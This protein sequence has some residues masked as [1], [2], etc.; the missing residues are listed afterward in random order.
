M[1]H[2]LPDPRSRRPRHNAL[3]PAAGS[4]ALLAVALT[5]CTST[6]AWQLAA[7]VRHRQRGRRQC[8][9]DLW[10]GV[11]IRRAVPLPA[12]IQQLADTMLQQITGPSGTHLLG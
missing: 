12:R 5:A 1:P 6:S 10:C 7:G 9:A 8:G 3:I 4:L 2:L 11:D